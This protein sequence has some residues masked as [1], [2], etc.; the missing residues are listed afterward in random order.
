MYGSAEMNRYTFYSGL[1]KLELSYKDRPD[2][3]LQNRIRWVIY[4]I[5]GAISQPK[6]TTSPSGE[7]SLG[8]LIDMY[9]TREATVPNDKVYALLGMSSNGLSATGLSPDYTVS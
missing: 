8:E 4:F 1:N 9:H 7:L 3:D 6:Y 5:R 2:P